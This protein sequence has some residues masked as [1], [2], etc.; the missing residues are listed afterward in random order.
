MQTIRSIKLEVW[1]ILVFVYNS[2]LILGNIIYQK[3]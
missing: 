3:V 1:S 2:S